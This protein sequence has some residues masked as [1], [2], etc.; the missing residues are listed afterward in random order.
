MN[1]NATADSDY[2]SDGLTESLID[3]LTHVPQLKVKSRNSVFRYKG[4]DVD[5]QK[6]GGELGVNALLTGRVLQRGDTV[7][8]SA[9]LT[10]VHDNTQIWGERYE[11][12][13]DNL[14][15]LQQQI[16]S[17][18][19]EKLRS[20]LTHTEKQRVIRPGTENE[21]AYLLYLKGRY[22]W[23]KRTGNDLRTAVSYF[24]QAIEKDP[25][26]AL[27][28]AGMADVYTIMSSYGGAPSDDY[29]KA[30]AAAEK[31]L[32]LDPTLAR[33]HVALGDYKYLHD[34]DFAGGEEEYQKALKLDPNDATTHQWHAE[35]RSYLLDP[36]EKVIAELQLAQDLDPL[37]SIIKI[38]LGDVYVTYRDY[39]RA[40]ERCGQVARDDPGFAK[41]HECL[42]WAYRGKRM[43][44]QV[45]EEYK[46]YGR[47]NGDDLDIAFA[48]ALEEGFQSSGWSG[49]AIQA[50]RVLTEQR[51]NRYVSA[52]TIA[53]L[54]ADAGDKE[55]AF[56]WLDVSFKERDESV[57]VLL[58]GDFVL[59]PLRSDPRFTAM[60]H[61]AG[62]Q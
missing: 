43:Y 62:L 58:K 9:E 16:A 40:L 3:S 56:H 57:V 19:A 32:A 30:R 38:V 6:L 61:Q 2:L 50:A 5:L 18:I 27:A 47:L 36:K 60:L 48:S 28:Y 12:K 29:P 37:S 10:D 4:K 23:N 39:D 52:V 22:Y 59:D 21:E 11:R 46:A 31:A 20:Q 15:A 33:P 41:A 24:D 13:S 25:R 17:D 49:A 1:K 14:I 55:A 45:V 44:A 35:K 54:Y 34:W 8:V 51:K 7:E 53:E 26:Y 42:A